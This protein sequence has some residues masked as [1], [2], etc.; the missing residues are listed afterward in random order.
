MD[1]IMLNTA[2]R[3]IV[4]RTG[5]RLPAYPGIR[6]AYINGLFKDYYLYNPPVSTKTLYK[7]TNRSVPYPRFLAHHYCGPKGHRRTL[8]DMMG[9]CDACTSISLLRQIQD[10]LYQWVSS[11]LPVV[12]AGTVCQHYV[13]SDANRHEIAVLLADVMHHA[14]CRDYD[15]NRPTDAGKSL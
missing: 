4:G 11:Y 14:L 2:C 5:R 7:Y 6:E 15:G 12:E 3:I 13:A 1:Q 8:S 10:E 9:I